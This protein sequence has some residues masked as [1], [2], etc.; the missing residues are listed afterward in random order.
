MK[1]P[2]HADRERVWSNE[3]NEIKKIEKCMRLYFLDL[4]ISVLNM[5]DG[6]TKQRYIPQKFLFPKV[7]VENEINL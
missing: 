1:I 4:V 7:A 2:N 5:L 3:K 6:I